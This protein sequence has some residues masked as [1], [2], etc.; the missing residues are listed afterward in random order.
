M[1]LAQRYVDV[2]LLQGVNMSQKKCEY[3]TDQILSPLY[4]GV[5]RWEPGPSASIKY[6]LLGDRGERTGRGHRVPMFVNLIHI[7]GE[8]DETATIYDNP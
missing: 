8:R 1:R 3:F 5:A 2:G 6:S 4:T 7:E